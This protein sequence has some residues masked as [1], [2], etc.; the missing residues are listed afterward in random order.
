[1]TRRSAEKMCKQLCKKD[2]NRW[3]H[4]HAWN[5]PV[6]VEEPVLEVMDLFQVCDAESHVFELEYVPAALRH[7]HRRWSQVAALG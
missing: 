5:P 2:R 6:E 7:G 3:G 1:M 4:D